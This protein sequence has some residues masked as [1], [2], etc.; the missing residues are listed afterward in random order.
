MP[1]AS[2]ISIAIGVFIGQRTKGDPVPGV[3]IAAW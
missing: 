1:R 2:N 3:S